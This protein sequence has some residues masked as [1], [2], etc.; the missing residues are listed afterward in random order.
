MCPRTDTAA[1]IRASA[2]RSSASG[3]PSPLSSRSWLRNAHALGDPFGHG[4]RARLAAH[5]FALAPCRRNRRPMRLIPSNSLKLDAF[6]GYH[7]IHLN[8][9]AQR[10]YVASQGRESVIVS[11]FQP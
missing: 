7:R 4:L 10:L 3:R 1:S 8:I 9:A 5:V 2:S 6:P 11:S